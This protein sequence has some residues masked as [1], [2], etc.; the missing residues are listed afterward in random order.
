MCLISEEFQSVTKIGTGFSEEDL[1]KHTEFFKD[2]IID[3]PKS[4]YSYDS[5][6]ECDVWFEPA[7]VW[8][9]RAADLSISPVHKA[10]VG[11]LHPSKGIALR[12]PRFLRVRDDKD[13]ESSTSAD[14]IVEMYEAQ[15]VVN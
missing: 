8:E 11:K 12:F 2:K 14:Q 13:P 3:T 4:Y 1:K 9:V 7:Q 5:K 10:A 15:S 6:M